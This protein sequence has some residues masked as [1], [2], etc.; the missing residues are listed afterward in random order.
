M[1]TFL[2]I[3]AIL[4]LIAWGCLRKKFSFGIIPVVFVSAI[5]SG[6]ICIIL[7]VSTYR[8]Y[9]PDKVR[10][11]TLYYM[12]QQKKFSMTEESVIGIESINL[13]KINKV[14]INDTLKVPYIRVI[15]R[16]E[17]KD[18]NLLWDIGFGDK[19]SHTLY[20]NPKQY[21]LYKSFKDSL[22][23]RNNPL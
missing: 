2:I 22:D 9:G 13:D 4:T 6:I 17:S 7:N 20:L 15:C 3:T 21:E 1:Y 16:H 8:I 10:N 5:L 12:S 19:I 11:D 18:M 23:K 14:I